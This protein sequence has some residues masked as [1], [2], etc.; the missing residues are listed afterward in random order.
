MSCGVG[1][2]LGSDPKLLWLWCRPA[3]TAPTRPLAWEPP[4][5]SGVALKR[6][7]PVASDVKQKPAARVTLLKRS[8]LSWLWAG[9]SAHQRSCSRAEAWPWCLSNTERPS[10]QL[11]RKHQTSVPGSLAR[12]LARSPAG[13]TPPSARRPESGGSTGSR[14]K[15]SRSGSGSGP[16]LTKTPG[17]SSNPTARGPRPGPRPR[18]HARPP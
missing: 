8:Q 13:P 11:L 5:A 3:A 7:K 9:G 14:G 18:H 15:H 2:R 6:Q 10:P 4:Y 1:R 17:Q 16:G 12:S